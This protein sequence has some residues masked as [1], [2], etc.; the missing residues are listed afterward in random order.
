MPRAAIER[1]VTMFRQRNRNDGES[2][3][4]VVSGREQNQ[5]KEVIDMFEDVLTDIIDV[6][7]R[8]QRR[9]SDEQRH[10]ATS[11]VWERHRGRLIGIFG[12]AG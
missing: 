10:S 11:E 9:I 5:E 3:S 1:L 7:I 6:N 2:M 12:Q 8:N 4:I